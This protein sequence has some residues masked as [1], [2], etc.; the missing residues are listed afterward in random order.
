ML[1]QLSYDHHGLVILLYLIG[2]KN[3]LA[4]VLQLLDG[5]A[6]ITQGPMIAGLLGGGKVDLRIPAAGQL[7][8]L[9][10]IH[11]SIVKVFVDCGQEAGDESSI[12]RDRIPG[13]G[14]L[15]SSWGIFI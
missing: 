11:G 14:R 10:D 15:P 13:Q 9:G 12:Y 2:Y 3:C 5:V 8:D 4:V 1:Y 6:N 7:L